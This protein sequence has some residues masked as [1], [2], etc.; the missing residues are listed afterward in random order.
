MKNMQMFCTVYKPVKVYWV[1]K[2][3]LFVSDFSSKGTKWNLVCVCMWVSV[4]LSVHANM[5]IKAAK[6][7]GLESDMEAMGKL[8]R[9]WRSVVPS[10]SSSSSSL[11][12]SAFFHQ[13]SSMQSSQTS[14]LLTQQWGAISGS[15]GPAEWRRMSV[16][17]VTPALDVGKVCFQLPN[18]K[19]GFFFFFFFFKHQQKCE[20]LK[21]EMHSF[22]YGDLMGPWFNTCFMLF[23]PSWWHWN[24]AIFPLN[25]WMAESRWFWRG[26]ITGIYFGILSLNDSNG[27]LMMTTDL[28][29]RTIHKAIL[30]RLH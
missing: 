19:K 28:I 27:H 14:L 22:S 11:P 26:A 12:H 3:K 7:D 20:I 1:Q 2:Q 13:L 30:C 23:P 25:K 5:W 24:D 21:N 16:I 17:A 8:T 18:W 15:V 29:H 10:S 6:W 4:C 9:S